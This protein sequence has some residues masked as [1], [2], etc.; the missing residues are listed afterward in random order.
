M[1]GSADEPTGI[2]SWCSLPTGRSALRCSLTGR[3]RSFTG[4]RRGVCHFAQWRRR[5]GQPRRSQ[6]SK[7]M[8]RDFGRLEHDEISLVE[9]L[10]VTSPARTAVDI[11]RTCDLVPAVAVA[12]AALHGKWTSEWSIDLALDRARG[13]TGIGTARQVMARADGS[14]ESV[15]ET[16][17]RLIFADFGLPEPER[18]VDIFDDDGVLVGR[19]DFLWREFGVIGECDGFGK[20][21]DDA[22]HAEIRRR[23]GAEKDRDAALMALGYRVF[24]WR[25]AD[26]GRPWLLAHRVRNVLRMAAAA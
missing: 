21:L 15:A 2:C 9:G 17:S 8:R 22:G 23:L 10:R 13:R 6:T 1:P 14:S 11:A 12:D 3:L 26:L 18:Q 25:W 19:V 7:L 4:C 5:P 16:R 20:Y 24:H